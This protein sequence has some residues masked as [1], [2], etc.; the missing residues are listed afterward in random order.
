MPTFCVIPPLLPRPAGGLLAASFVRPAGDSETLA[1]TWKQHAQVLLSG[2]RD[3][4]RTAQR[5]LQGRPTARG[6][7]RGRR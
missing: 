5:A 6:R 3:N 2:A 1:E 4:V 7:G